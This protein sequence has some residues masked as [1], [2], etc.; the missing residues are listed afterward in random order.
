MSNPALI[1]NFGDLLEP[2]HRKVYVDE[3]GL[4]PSMIPILFQEIKS[5]KP[6]ET[7]TG[8]GEF[9]DWSNFTNDPQIDYQEIYQLYDKKL[10]YIEWATGYRISRRLLQDDRYR[11][12]A[13]RPK[14]M[15]KSGFNMKEKHGAAVFNESFT[16]QPSDGYGTELCASDNPYNSGSNNTWSNEGT[17][18]LNVTN[19]GATRLLMMAFK[20]DREELGDTNP[21][22]LIVP[23]ALEEQAWEI[24]NSTGK[25]DTAENNPN[26]HKGKYKLIVWDKL[27]DTNNW[28]MVDFDKMKNHLLFINRVPPEFHKDKEFDTFEAK[29]S[30]YMAYVFGWTTPTDWIFG[31]LVA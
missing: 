9:G 14:G 30:G 15:A 2:D 4:R 26:F 23:R 11:V 25:V 22:G 5:T 8:V 16:T 18:A 1:E 6:W 24:I 3:W 7:F 21:D 31:N 28:W 20:N 17:Y 13:S 27:T 19:V 12:I 10:T 29:F